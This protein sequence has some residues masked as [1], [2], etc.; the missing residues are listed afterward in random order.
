MTHLVPQDPT[1]FGCLKR[2]LEPALCFL[3]EML[4]QPSDGVCQ[5]LGFRIVDQIVDLVSVVQR[6]GLWKD[7]SQAVVVFIEEMCALI[8]GDSHHPVAHQGDEGLRPLSKP[9]VQVLS[10]NVRRVETCADGKKAD[11]LKSLVGGLVVQGLGERRHTWIDGY[12]AAV[13]VALVGGKVSGSGARAKRDVYGQLAPV[14][15]R[16]GKVMEEFWLPHP[17]LTP[18][19]AAVQVERRD[20][21]A[22]AEARELF[23]P[24]D[25]LEHIP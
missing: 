3:V 17:H 8:V 10:L 2:W 25:S 11:I 7:R 19:L 22:F 20:K 24:K 18:D 14:R 9:P 4:L 23:P 12:H 15:I 1:P 13:D 5:V 6:D 21:N 16:A